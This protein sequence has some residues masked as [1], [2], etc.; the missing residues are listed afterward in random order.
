MLALSLEPALCREN[1]RLAENLAE[2]ECLCRIRHAIPVRSCGERDLSHAHRELSHEDLP[3]QQAGLGAGDLR[4]VPGFR[5][6]RDSDTDPGECEPQ[7]G[8][9]LSIGPREQVV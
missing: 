3:S 5:A 7:T 6:E 9:L 1:T 2:K 8:V 4:P